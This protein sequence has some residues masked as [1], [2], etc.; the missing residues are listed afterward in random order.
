MEIFSQ[1]AGKLLSV[2]EQP[3]V[4]EGSWDCTRTVLAEFPSREDA[5]AWYQSDA[6]QALAQ[7]RFAASSA[8]LAVVA[9]L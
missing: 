8:N 3:E 1:Y 4:L 9:G 5:M 7:H 2:D 6:Y